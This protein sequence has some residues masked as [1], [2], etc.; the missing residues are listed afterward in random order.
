MPKMLFLLKTGTVGAF[1]LALLIFAYY[2][3]FR[4]RVLV[5]A[6]AEDPTFL[7]SV[8]GYTQKMAYKP[9]DTLRIYYHSTSHK[10]K[11]TLS[12]MD[13]AYTYRE[14]DTFK[15]SQSIENF[16]GNESTEGCNWKAFVEIQLHPEKYAPGYYQGKFENETDTTYLTFLIENRQKSKVAV[17]LPLTTWT[18]YNSWG[19]QS[20]YVNEL[21][22]KNTYYAAVNRP[23]NAATYKFTGNT[24]PINIEAH[25]ANYFLSQHDAMLLPDYLLESAPELLADVE[26]VVLAYHCEYFSQKMYDNLE[27]LI[28]K[29]QK[30]LLSLGGN[31]IYWK[32]RWNNNMT[33]LEC[34][35]DLTNFS[36]SSFWNYGGMWKHHF[37]NEASLLGSRY[38]NR[39][40]DSYA[41]Y[42]VTDASHWL[43]ANCKVQNGDLFGFESVDNRPISGDE[44]DKQT[45]L[46]G[47]S[48]TLIAKGMNCKNCSGIYQAN[49]PQ[50][51]GE[52]GGDVI[53]KENTQNAILSFS[54]IHCG[55]GLGLSPV[56]TQMVE[57]FI[58]KYK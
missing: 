35:K 13:G 18:A 22:R 27:K 46:Y 8:Q 23:N 56:F 31:Q 36:K 42:K 19:G 43:Y 38:D 52:G 11:L 45:L 41:P 6:K 14:I 53:I 28:H 7:Q 1:F 17:L 4:F 5:K 51:T 47:K 9:N 39:G 33:Q 15:L 34:R 29:Q 26:V 40:N 2:F 44:T 21:E 48:F 20:L 55:A 24:I 37:R 10:G 25:I 3:H 49:E 54:S 50:W 32:V 58:A 30:S 16:H 57:N 12:R